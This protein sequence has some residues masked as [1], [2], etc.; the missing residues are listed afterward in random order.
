MQQ[1]HMALDTFVLAIYQLTRTGLS[2]SMLILSN[3][4]AAPP[5]YTQNPSYSTTS[6]LFP[7]TS[8]RTGSFKPQTKL[9]SPSSSPS[10]LQ[11][12]PELTPSLTRPA[13]IPPGF[14]VKRR[15]TSLSQCTPETCL[16]AG[17]APHHPLT[18]ARPCPPWSPPTAA[19]S[20]SLTPT[21]PG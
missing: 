5:R 20:T 19:S 21:W 17:A 14:W 6:P 2:T 11:I 12:A 10:Y 8:P 18:A 9:A 3:V 15:A 13:H 16:S 4:P 7:T 1:L